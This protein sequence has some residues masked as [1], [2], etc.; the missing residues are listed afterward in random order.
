MK[1]PTMWVDSLEFRVQEQ[2]PLC[3]YIT[4]FNT[5][6]GILPLSFPDMYKVPGSLTDPIEGQF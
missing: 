1:M 3:K 6:N 2:D 5:C 4:N